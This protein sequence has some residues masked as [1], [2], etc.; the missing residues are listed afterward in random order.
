MRILVVDCCSNSLNPTRNLLPVLFAKLGDVD[1]FGPGYTPIMELN[2]GIRN[3]VGK[4]EPYDAMI[5]TEHCANPPVISKE[6]DDKNWK[7][8]KNSF[9]F[10]FTR[11]ELKAFTCRMNEMY[12]LNI[13]KIISLMQFDLQAINENYI[14]HIS[15]NYDLAIGMGKQF[16]RRIDRREIKRLEG[17]E[18]CNNNWRNYCESNEKKVFSCPHIIGNDEFKYN[19]YEERKFDW[20]LLG[21]NYAQRKRARKLLKLRKIQVKDNK[22]IIYKIIILAKKLNIFKNINKSPDN[23]MVRS[24]RRILK[25]SKY[26]YT[27]G[28]YLRIL[29]RKYCEIPA[30]GCL[31]VAAEIEGSD[32]LG[33][34]D[35]ENFFEI[36]ADEIVEFHKFIKKNPLKA[37][38]VAKKGQQMI[39]TKHTVEK[40]A[41][42]IHK[43]IELLITKKYNG[44]YWKEGEV[45]FYD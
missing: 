27:C 44:S 31:L 9:D 23:F 22:T 11:N 7:R 4:N 37:K 14:N 35:M 33:F 1:F 25:E 3:F 26:S 28:S 41:G 24:F 12:S 21:T 13:P 20:S 40:R 15:N 6:E 17:F 38:E 45:Y 2:K 34:K 10:Q 8:Y 18:N 43:A 5:V 19:N 39:L 32:E 29:T 42:Q 36:K 16:F 30:N